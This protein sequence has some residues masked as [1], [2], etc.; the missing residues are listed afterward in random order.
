[1]TVGTGAQGFIGIAPEVTPGTYAAP[2]K[3]VPIMSESL[4]FQQATNFRRPIRASADVIG[5]VQGDAHTEGDL[6]ME[7]FEEVVPYFLLS[8]RTTMVKSGST[9]NFIYTFVGSAAAVPVKTMSIT[10]VR[11]GIVFGYT[12]CVVSSWHFTIDNGTLMF[13]PSIIGQDEAV[14]TLPTATWPT[15]ET[16]FGVGTYDIQIP[17]ATSVFDADGFDFSVDDSGAPQYRLKNTGRGAQFVSFGERSVG[18]SLQRDFQTRADYDAFKALTA[19]GV[20]LIASKGINNLISLQIPAA[21]K[22]TYEV[23]LSGQGDLTRASIAYVGV[24]DSGGNAYTVV[25]KTQEDIT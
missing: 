18:L 17:T 5:A 16:P 4:K 6:T 23:G 25:C 2:T 20:T 1:M 19:Q 24:V 9:P 3:F 21:V 22:D 8:A 14:Q 15:T 11:N 13:N 12:G 7:A 10:V